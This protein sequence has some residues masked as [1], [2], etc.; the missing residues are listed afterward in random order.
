MRDL[1]IPS[2]SSTPYF[3]GDTF[4]WKGENV[5][6]TEVQR[7]CSGTGRVAAADVYGVAVPQNDGR[8]G[9]AAVFLE[10]GAN[11][12]ETLKALYQH[13]AA[14]LPKYARPVF[15]RIVTEV[16]VR[17]LFRENVDNRLVRTRL[18]VVYGVGA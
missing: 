12:T 10:P 6:T 1:P 17:F 3:S 5:A 18:F 16:E 9:M 11:P 8:C 7:V 2:F 14:H 13:T 4:R 15:V